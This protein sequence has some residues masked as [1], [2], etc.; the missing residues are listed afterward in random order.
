MSGAVRGA[1][2]KAARSAWPW[3][4]RA[5]RFSWLKAAALLGEAAPGLYL[6][7]G[8]AAGALGPRPV[9]EA[10]H[11]TGLMAI[12][13]L[14]LSLAV[15]PARAL[16][17]WQ[18]LALVRRQLGLAALF[19]ALAH[20]SLYALDQKWALLHVASEI[21]LRFYLTIGFVALCGLAA[22]GATSTDGMV[23]RMGRRWKA[24]HRLAYL[25]AGLGTFHFFLQSKS[26]VSEATLMAG[27]FLWLMAWR[28]L[29]AG[30]D[31]APLPVL[32]LAG[33]AALGTVAAEF[34]W[35]ALATHIDPARPVL[36]ELDWTYGPHPAGQALLL[37]LCL[38]VG[39]ALSWARQR[40]RLRG[41]LGYDVA[42]YAGGAL[43]VA[44]VAYAFALTDAWLPDDWPAWQAAGA[45][46]LAAG[47]LGVG[48]WALP[49]ARRLIDVVCAAC[50]LGP[51]VA[52]LAL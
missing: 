31:R 42:L 52:G 1:R 11:A 6:A 19:Y 43:I 47:A 13:F 38:A 46:M 48:R 32:G 41:T 5:G 33:A 22:L 15:S 3:D 50:L 49:P 37:G 4:D 30:A 7:W 17:G 9:T 40:E 29:P 44:G 35:F 27:M 16:F 14:L 20:L 36:M 51:L 2:R 24:L 21:A 26:D 12:R 8:W 45:F 23:R 18:R 34:A 25:I 10:I 39:T 28:A